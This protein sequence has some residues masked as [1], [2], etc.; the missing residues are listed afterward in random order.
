MVLP[1][2]DDDDDNNDD[3]NVVDDDDDDNDDDDDDD[4]DDGGGGRSD[5][6]DEIKIS[7]AYTNLMSK[8]CIRKLVRISRY[9]R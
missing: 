5:R 4:D 8:T 2:D 6:S 3:D 1:N 7:I 9:N